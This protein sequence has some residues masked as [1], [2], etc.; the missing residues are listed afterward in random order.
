M[1]LF[2][3]WQDLSLAEVINADKKIGHYNLTNNFIKTNLYIYIS[4][5]K[6]IHFDLKKHIIH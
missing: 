1:F 5:T 4:H 2:Q 6:V 3:P